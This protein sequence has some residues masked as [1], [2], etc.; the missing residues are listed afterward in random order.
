M[1]DSHDTLSNTLEPPT[2][3][4]QSSPAP[5]N[6]G[7][8]SYAMAVVEDDDDDL[9][10]HCGKRDPS[11]SSGGSIHW[12]FCEACDGWYH[13]VCE[14]VP[15]GAVLDSHYVCIKCKSKFL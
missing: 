1:E 2:T 11:S 12:V 5:A 3:V 7:P 9:C 6:P 14:K 8:S 13:Q 10:S 15:A 4:Q